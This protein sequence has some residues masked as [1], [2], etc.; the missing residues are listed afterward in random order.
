MIFSVQKEQ[1]LHTLHEE[2]I[3]RG[4][5]P[6]AAG[7]YVR[8]IAQTLTDKDTEEIEQIRDPA[9][10]AK[11]AQGIVMV[12][13]RSAAQ[14]A[15]VSAPEDEDDDVK[16][17]RGAGSVP[18][19]EPT[20]PTDTDYDEYIRDDDP[21]PQ[22][23]ARGKRIFWLIFICALPLTLILLLAYFG[24]FGAIFAALCA[25]IV[26]LVA[27]LIGGAAVGAVVSLVGIVYG[28]MQLITAASSAPGLYEIGLGITVGG[29]VMAGG[30]IVYNIAIR[31][32]PL[33]IR[34]LASLFGF[35]T[36]KLRTL[37]QMAKEACYRL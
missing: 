5:P 26:L 2:L 28:I 15:P 22:A 6:A 3:K 8:A 33:L 11:L 24:V 17:Y 37:F 13:Q 18:R 32:I 21:E 10:V 20:P 14:N 19:K 7:Q 34:L 4:I 35:C 16:V 1:F 30:I 36:G 23:S 9:D 12:K 29:V 27:G 31:L 25:V